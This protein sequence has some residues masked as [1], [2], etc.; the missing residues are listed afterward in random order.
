[1][2]RSRVWRPAWIMSVRTGR[3][4]AQVREFEKGGERSPRP[5]LPR[6]VTDEAADLLACL[7]ASRRHLLERPPLGI[8]R[9]TVRQFPELRLDEVQVFEEGSRVA[10]PPARVREPWPRRA[11]G[12]RG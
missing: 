11:R 2:Y 6:H 3:I 10:A 7:V 9:L 12:P 1:M 5:Q 4:V 8:A